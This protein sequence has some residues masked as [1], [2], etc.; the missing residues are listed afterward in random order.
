MSAIRYTVNSASTSINGTCYQGNVKTTYD[1]LVQILG[2]PK[3]G[4]ADGK[5]T[6]EWHL[7]F[8]DGSV[9]TIYDWKM[10]TTPKEEHNWHVGGKDPVSLNYLQEALGI[11]VVK[12]KY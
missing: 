7:E 2:Q 8:Q 3:G 4:S 1:K 10:G 12:A 9:A 6:C 5:T 11:E